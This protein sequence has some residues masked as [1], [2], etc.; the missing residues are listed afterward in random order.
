MKKIL[1]KF[2]IIFSIIVVILNTITITTFANIYKK[3]LYSKGDCGRLLKKGDVVVKTYIVVYNDNG[4]EYPA[5]CLDKNKAGVDDNITYDVTLD[6]I[7]K[8]VYI[9]K[10]ITNGYPYKTPQEMGCNSIGEAF[11]AT[12]MAVYSVLY[13]YTINDFS[14]IGEAGQRTWNALNNIL[15]KVNDGNNTQI[16][17]KLNIEEK[18]SDWEENKEMPGYI[19]KEFQVN[20]EGPMN[21]YTIVKENGIEGMIITDINNMPSQEFEANEKFRISIPITEL[22]DGG[23][24]KLK[25]LANVETK[26][27]FIGRAANSNNQDYAVTG[28]S[29]ENGSGEKEVYY[30]KNETKIKIIKKDET[31][32]KNLANA[33]FQLLDK[34]KKVIIS[35]LITNQNGEI[36]LENIIPGTYYIKEVQAPAGYILYD[37]YIQIRPKFN[38]ELTITIKNTK[39]EKPEVEISKNLLKLKNEIKRLPKTG[40]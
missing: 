16:S 8:N 4:K 33:I 24:I 9:W 5:Y 21:T 15:L 27:I 23:S 6:G 1:T 30:G 17:A 37:N 28:I 32:E 10:A 11:M 19:S 25:A 35:E 18:S 36:V 39:E 26:P 14:P 34:D 40:M 13:N 29:Y 2:I 22:S 31:G 12:K 7:I 20:A 38:E 3:N